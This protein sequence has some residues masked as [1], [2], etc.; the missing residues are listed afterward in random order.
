MKTQLS[1]ILVSLQ[2]YFYFRVLLRHRPEFRRYSYH[3]NALDLAHLLAPPTFSTAN[4]LSRAWT[5][6]LSPS[7][8]GEKRIGACVYRVVVM[9]SC[10][11]A[12]WIGLKLLFIAFSLSVNCASRSDL[13][14]Y[15]VQFGDQILQSGN[16]ETEKVHLDRAVLFFDGNFEEVYVS[17]FSFFPFLFFLFSFPLKKY[18][19]FRNPPVHFY[20]L[21]IQ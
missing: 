6:I 16:D 11:R 10:A 8:L 21:F 18:L 5:F 13:F 14:D 20:I 4:P 1:P 19:A 7:P 3:G 17:F 9:A 12:V 15:G 2:W